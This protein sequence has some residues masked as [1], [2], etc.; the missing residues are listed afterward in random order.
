MNIKPLSYSN[1]TPAKLHKKMSSN[2]G[3]AVMHKKLILNM[4]V[5]CPDAFDI[6]DILDN[7]TMMQGMNDRRQ[8]ILSP[9]HHT[10]NG[11]QCPNIH[12]SGVF[13]A[14]ENDHISMFLHIT[15]GY[16][17]MSVGNFFAYIASS[18]MYS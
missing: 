7:S 3:S 6:G 10:T 1:N 12:I 15:S 9:H 17:G 8:H 16:K 11:T 18:C 5:D 13:N 2:N 4:S 14:D